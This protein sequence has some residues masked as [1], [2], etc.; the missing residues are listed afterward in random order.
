MGSLEKIYQRLDKC[1]LLFIPWRRRKHVSTKHRYMSIR[2]HGV[3]LQK[4][5]TFICTTAATLNFELT[6]TSRRTAHTSHY[7]HWSS[8]ACF[9]TGTTPLR[10]IDRGGIDSR[11]IHLNSRGRCQFHNPAAL[12]RQKWHQHPVHK[13]SNRVRAF[14]NAMEK[15]RNSISVSNRSQPPQTSIPQPWHYMKLRLFIVLL[16]K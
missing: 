6:N 8:Q 14:Q 12:S 13:R 3:I 10:R 7:I 5:A 11:I 4:T 1:C 2:L 9:Y 15:R 16:L